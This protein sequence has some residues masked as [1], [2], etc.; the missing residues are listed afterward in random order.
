MQIILNGK[1]R[2]LK[3]IVSIEQLL[4]ELGLKPIGLVVEL[5]GQILRQEQWV[6]TKVHDSD[7]L[8]IISFVGG[9]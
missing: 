9:G 4:S 1:P 6:Q 8:E 2:E 7:N 3:K 5:N